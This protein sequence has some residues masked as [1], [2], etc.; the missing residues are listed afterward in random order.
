MKLFYRFFYSKAINI[1]YR[2]LLFPIRSILPNAMRI[3]V[4]GTLAIK[5]KE[6]EKQLL[7]YSNESC[8]MVRHLYWN[9]AGFT[10]E[11]SHI[12]KKLILEAETFVDIGA[13][14]GYYSLLGAVLKPSL[15]V[16]SFEP[17]IGPLY[18]LKRNVELNGFKNIQVI[19]SA[20]GNENGTIS[21]FEE[22]NLKY[23][24]LQHHASGIGNT[25]NSWDIANFSKYD[26]N[27]TTLDAVL[28][29]QQQHK[30]DLIKMDTE[31]TENCVL[32]GALETILK[33][34]PIII[35]EVLHGKIEAEMDRVIKDQMHYKIYQFLEEDNTLRLVKDLSSSTSP[36]NEFTNYFFVPASKES[37]I[38][39]FIKTPA[40]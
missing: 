25:I 5:D 7:F 11:F 10:F 14:V 20:V 9:E 31:G 3:P 32:E 24:Y 29:T 36:S 15:V 2:N 28:A 34:Q 38:Q 19:E 17:S 40:V 27:L 16:Y 22:R 6:S 26:V 4:V 37:L 21:F 8:P 13:N 30:I 39:E 18:F 12:F 33:Y 35:C 1:I 23:N